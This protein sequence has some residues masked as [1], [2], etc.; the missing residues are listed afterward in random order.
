MIYGEDAPRGRFP[1][2][3]TLRDPYTG[4]EYCAGTL[5]HPEIVLTAGHCLSPD[6][7]PF[8][9]DLSPIVVICGDYRPSEDNGTDIL[10]SRQLAIN[11]EWKSREADIG[12]LWLARPALNTPTVAVATP[13]EWG[14][15][16][17]EGQ[18]L[19][20]VGFGR[21]NMQESGERRSFPLVLQEFQ[22]PI[23]STDTCNELYGGEVNPR[24]MMCVGDDDGG[25]ATCKGDSGGPMVY[26]PEDVDSPSTHI[27]VA[28]ISWSGD[29]C[30]TAEEPDVNTKVS[31]FYDW[32]QQG[33]SEVE[34]VSK[35]A[36]TP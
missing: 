16:N 1:Y 32:I 22:A 8:D 11:P 3:C 6:R 36:N 21:L 27:Q 33:I 10:R 12:L 7:L 28:I 15:I 5:I 35:A 14:R 34:G 19:W 13:K 26:V 31:A 17:V 2:M 18:E 23:L 20:G 24:T 9:P 25:P 30:G 29:S 4:A